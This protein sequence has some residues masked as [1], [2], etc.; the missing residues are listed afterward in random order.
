MD[1]EKRISQTLKPLSSFT[2][3]KW[4]DTEYEIRDVINVNE[5]TVF[6]RFG[7]NNTVLEYHYINPINY[8]SLT[9]KNR[10]LVD[11]C[12][13][14]INTLSPRGKWFLEELEKESPDEKDLEFL[15]YKATW[16]NT[17][18]PEQ[19]GSELFNTLLV[20][21]DLYGFIRLFMLSAEDIPATNNKEEERN[22]A[23]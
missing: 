6:L 14:I 3:E 22:D 2:Q 18:P 10:Q 15:M 17:Y 4:S 20:L 11:N 12:L 9:E 8:G 21:G 13:S 5:I 1:L 23:T 16:P 7:K 19:V